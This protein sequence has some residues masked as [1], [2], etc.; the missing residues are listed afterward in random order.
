MNVSS[1]SDLPA[2]GALPAAVLV[3]N[4]SIVYRGGVKAI[5]SVSL[6]VREGEFLSVV[7]PSGCGKTTLLTAIARLL[8]P[9]VARVE[10]TIRVD[11]GRIGYVFQRDTL[12]PWRT[13]L[14]NVETGLEVRGWKPRARREVARR[15]V[16][17]F[18]LQGFE[19][20]YPH[21]ISGGMRQRVALARTLAYEPDVILMDEPF[22]AVDAQTRII[23]QAELTRIWEQSRPTVIFV[24]HDLAEAISLSQR[25][26]VFSRRP[27]RIEVER[28]VDLPWPRDPFRLRNDKRF[29]QLHSDLWEV[30]SAQVLKQLSEGAR[31]P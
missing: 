5:D 31:E 8:E 12:L 26:V 16:E 18:G 28:R 10:G 3:E 15:Y 20:A 30:L 17:K 4:V 13:V 9:A 29:L 1:A 24:T 21:Q 2:A 27:G 23:L 22:A 7:G 14:Q 25:T 19:N 11:A 6:A